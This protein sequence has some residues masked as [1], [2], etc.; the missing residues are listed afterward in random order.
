[1]AYVKQTWH[2]LPQTDT[3]ITA[4]RMNHI[5]DGIADVDSRIPAVVPTKLSDLTND[6]G[7]ITSSSNITGTSSNVTGT[8]AVGH[9]GTGATTVAGAR[10]ALGLGNTS[11][12]VPVANG[13]TG[14][15]SAANARTNL[16]LVNAYNDS[17]FSTSEVAVGTWI[18]GK[19]VYKKQF[20]SQ[21]VVHLENLVLLIIYQI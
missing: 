15:S 1:M 8:V 5:E 4:S 13:G 18:D 21:L 3:P 12:A 17:N 11:G 14:A 10:N 7:F 6:V 9:G 19:T 16:G 20:H 2:D